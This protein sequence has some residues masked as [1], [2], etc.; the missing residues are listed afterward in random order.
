MPINTDLSPICPLLSIAKPDLAPCSKGLCAWWDSAA[1]RCAI[2]E[3][4]AAI[5]SAGDNV[6][7][8]VEGLE[9]HIDTVA[10]EISKL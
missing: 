7:G 5:E 8:A 2:H 4:P 10:Q 9:V 1:R 3:L 6:S